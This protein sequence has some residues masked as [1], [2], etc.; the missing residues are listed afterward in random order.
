MILFIIVCVCVNAR[1][2]YFT[3][4]KIVFF[5]CGHLWVYNLLLSSAQSQTGRFIDQQWK[6]K[7]LKWHSFL[8]L[9][10]SEWGRYPTPHIAFFFSTRAVCSS[11]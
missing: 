11:L 10:H 6:Y 5:V 3:F 8:H 9:F 4:F 2:Y 7:I 1:R